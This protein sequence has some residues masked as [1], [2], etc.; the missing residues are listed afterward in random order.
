MTRG[1]EKGD[2][3]AQCCLGDYYAEGLGVEIDMDEALS[4]YQ[5]SAAQKNEYAEYNLGECY[6]LGKGVEKDLEQAIHWYTLSAEQGYEDAI[7][8]LERLKNND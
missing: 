4:L 2:S 6:E 7:E 1:A 3:D 5:L 8:A